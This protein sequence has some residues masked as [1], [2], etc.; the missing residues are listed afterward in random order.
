MEIVLIRHGQPEWVK[1]GEYTVDPG[2]TEIGKKQAEKSASTFEKHSIDE[3]W[4]SPLNRA[5][6][7][8]KPFEQRNIGCK[9]KTFDWLREALDD[10][11]KKLIGESQ[12]T[13]REYFDHRNTRSFEDWMETTHGAYMKGFSENIVKNLEESLSD[14]GVISTDSRYDRLF[15]LSSSKISKLMIISHAGTM[16]TLLSY[17]LNLPLYPWTWRKFL[18]RHAGHT[19]LRSTEISSGHFFRM[20]EFNN[21]SFMDN[22]ELKTY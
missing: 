22:G 11:E 17:L 14:I 10:D 3:I 16:S 6:E 4:V 2:L 12:E 8:L 13:I 9:I 5:K 7:T 15:D 21:V 19:F 20:K 1:D 18:P